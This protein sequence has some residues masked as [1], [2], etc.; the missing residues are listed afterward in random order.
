MRRNFIVGF[1][2]IACL[3]S[4]V[5]PSTPLQNDEG[6]VYNCSAWGFGVIGTIAALSATQNCVDKMKAAGWHP[7][8]ETSAP[9]TPISAEPGTVI[10]ESNLAATQRSSQ[11]SPLTEHREPNMLCIGA[12]VRQWDNC[13]GTF[14]YP[15]GNV[16]RGEFHDGMRQGFGVIN[17]NARGVSDEHNILS[18]E[19]A[20]YI[21]EF[22]S[23]RLNGHGV[24]FT[25]SGAIYAGTFVNNIPQSDLS[26]RNCSGPLP[27]AWTN[28][29]AAHTY[30]N[31]NVYRGEFA[32]GK[33]QGVGLIE[34]HATGASDSNSIR[35]P[36]PGIYIGEFQG[37]RLNGHGVIMMP[38]SAFYG[39]FRDNIL[40]LI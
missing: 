28:C 38:G 32:Q 26:Q 8:G 33:R 9:A 17:I 21:G 24:W 1:L 31:G 39:L 16:Y 13:V 14:T 15:N 27:V 12:D 5:T 3:T 29:V 4:C 18:S 37:D 11:P 35:T 30:P 36:V 6:R 34:I 19:Q 23:D 40:M 25:A 20:E 7:A 10:S 22:R 2:G